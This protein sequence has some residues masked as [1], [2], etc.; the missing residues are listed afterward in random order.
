MGCTDDYAARIIRNRA[1]LEKDYVVPYIGAE[2]MEKLVTKAQFYRYCD[3][4]G[5]DYPA[6]VVLHGPQDA[7]LLDD[8]PFDWPV[9]IKP[10][11]SILYWKHPFDG[12]QKVYLAQ[13]A[14]EAKAITGRIY[15]AGYPDALIVQDRV[16]GA[17][18]G[19]RV[20][21]AYSD[22]N[23]KVQM[24]CLGHVLLE[25]HTPRAL[26]NHAAILTEY[27]RPLMEKVQGFL[28]AVGY[29]GFSNFDIKY[30]PRDGRYKL[31]E[32]NLRQGRSNYYVTGAGLNIA[33]C[34]VEDRV[35]KQDPGEPVFFEGGTFWR[36]IPAKVVWEYTA[37][38]QLVQK[39][40]A[41]EAAGR[42]S[43]A[44]GYWYDLKGNPLRRLYLWEHSRR[45]HKK[46]ATYCEK[47]EG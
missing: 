6:T 16:P 25:E 21:T 15:G 38:A 19:M 12:M 33:R 5:L 14:E 11:S 8:L 41:A 26:G 28:E 32:I 24:M 39:A 47:R 2:L 30:D 7:P 20:L 23:R 44:L 13:D 1:A 31:F 22:R 40:Q 43:T 3:A 10:S 46:Y 29:T 17:D 34:V 4:F 9:I 45:Y 35:L 42:G 18:C 36:S 27:D 37:D